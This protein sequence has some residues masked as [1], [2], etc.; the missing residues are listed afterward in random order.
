MMA[1]FQYLKVGLSLVLVFVGGKMLIAGV[2]KIPIVASLG[3]IVALLGGAIV[4]SL[5]PAKKPFV[6]HPAEVGS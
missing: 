1:K 6:D 3:V 4:A 2:Y 5:R